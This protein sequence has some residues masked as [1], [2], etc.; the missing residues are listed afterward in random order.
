[1]Y[2]ITEEEWIQ[3]RDCNS[4]I[5]ATEIPLIPFHEGAKLP[6]GSFQHLIIKDKI[7]NQWGGELLKKKIV[8]NRVKTIWWFTSDLRDSSSVDF[9][10]QS[11]V[12]SC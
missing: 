10:G 2:G 9:D 5:L 12:P 3:A 1:M 6:S 7:S 8:Q 4:T 11:M